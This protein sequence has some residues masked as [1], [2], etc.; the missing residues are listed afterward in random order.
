VVEKQQNKTN[1][2]LFVHDILSYDGDMA[3]FE[4]FRETHAPLHHPCANRQSWEV[5]KHSWLKI[6][7]IMTNRYTTLKSQINDVG[8]Q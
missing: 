5:I 7:D 6:H 8:C 2:T 4:Y 3:R 1:S